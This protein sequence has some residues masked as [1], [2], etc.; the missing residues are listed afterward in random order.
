MIIRNENESILS[1]S[2]YTHYIPTQRAED[3]CLALEK[4]RT[5]IW[6]HM[7][8]HAAPTGEGEWAAW[9]EPA[10]EPTDDTAGAA[11]SPARPPARA[12]A[13]SHSGVRGGMS[14]VGRRGGGGRGDRQR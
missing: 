11:S 14:G 4:A 6:S 3:E 1:L 9:H 8:P 5:N 10:H 13:G 2:I 12:G 7:H